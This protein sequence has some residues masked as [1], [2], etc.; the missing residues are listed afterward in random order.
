MELKLLRFDSGLNDTL[1]ILF[2]DGKFAGF[3]LEDEHREIKVQGET[4]IPAGTY[5]IKYTYSP[6]YK[7]LML[8]VMNVPNF[9]GIRIHPGNTEQDTS[10]CILVGNICRH[11]PFG[12]SRIEESRLAYDRIASL[13]IH[14]LGRK[15]NVTL[16]IKDN[17]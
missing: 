16:E 15:E 14:A 7:K 4:R 3:T 11:N 8:E 6:K 9:S 1:G 13:I 5:D 12:N 17:V 2:M 10:G